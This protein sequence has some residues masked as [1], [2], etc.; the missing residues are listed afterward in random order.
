[1][2]EP[3]VHLELNPGRGQKVDDG[4][5]FEFTRPS[6]EQAFADQPGIGVHQ[7]IMIRRLGCCPRYVATKT[8][9]RTTHA[10]CFEII[11]LPIGISHYEIFAIG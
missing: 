4:G 3:V 6:G 1:M 8:H 11:E 2:R 5:R 7:L 10:G 9:A